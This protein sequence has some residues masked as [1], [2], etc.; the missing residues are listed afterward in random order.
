MATSHKSISLASQPLCPQKEGLVLY[1]QC[2]CVEWVEH[3]HT[4]HNTLLTSDDMDAQNMQRWTVTA[5]CLKQVGEK[6]A[7]SALMQ[8]LLYR[9]R[10]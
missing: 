2:V 1:T 4:L 9:I 3:K 6:L 10:T 7:H 8:P 5:R